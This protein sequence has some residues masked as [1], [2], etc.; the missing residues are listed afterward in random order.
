MNLVLAILSGICCAFWVYVLFSEK[1]VSELTV[2]TAFFLVALSCL[3]DVFYF[4]GQ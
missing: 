3:V 2:K 1:E 4:L